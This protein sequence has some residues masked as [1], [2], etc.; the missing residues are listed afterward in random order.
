MPEANSLTAGT[1][2]RFAT[3]WPVVYADSC[4]ALSRWF[5]ETI[6]REVEI[7]THS[8]AVKNLGLPNITAVEGAWPEARYR[9]FQQS[10]APSTQAVFEAVKAVPRLSTRSYPL[11][12]FTAH[13]HRLIYLGGMLS[14]RDMEEP[15]LHL[16]VFDNRG[17]QGERLGPDW[18]SL[19]STNSNFHVVDIRDVA[20]HDTPLFVPPLVTRLR[21]G[22]LESA[23]YYTALRLWRSLP[24]RLGRGVALIMG[25]N[26]LQREA[27]ASLALK[28]F[29]L[30]IV[31]MP[32]S[33]GIDAP[34]E[35]DTAAT[36][37]GSG[38]LSAQTA[39]WSSVRIGRQLDGL[40]QRQATAMLARHRSMTDAC[41]R[42]L[43][44]HAT[45]G[46]T[47]LLVDSAATIAR[48]PL[49]EAARRLHIPVVSCQH[50]VT[51]EIR[52]T[53][54]EVAVSYENGASDFLF[55]YNAAAA[56]VSA[57]SIYARGQSIATGAPRIFRR[58]EA[59]RK[60]DFPFMYISTTLL[61]S[62][63]NAF[64][65]WRTDI[66][67]AGREAAFIDGVLAKL[68]GR[69]LYKPYPAIRYADANPVV[70]HARTVANLSIVDRAIDLRYM[71]GNARVM[72]TMRATSTLGWCLA[73]KR[74][75]V[76]IDLPGDNPLS[77][78]AKDA[79]KPS[80]FLFDA[81]EPDWMES[82]VCLLSQ[83]LNL[84]EDEW[85]RRKS[86]RAKALEALV[87]GPQQSAGKLAAREILASLRQPKLSLE[88]PS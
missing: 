4:E 13:F 32:E 84:L 49:A 75:V 78:D 2:A 87:F 86:S 77:K 56:R 44:P 31:G 15:R 74:P 8:P 21:F 70:A 55:T 20:L 25:D 61:R 24:A 81:G 45:K 79:L 82:I 73:S 11:A 16:R 50:G 67:R 10:I 60:P 18:S 7:R 22:G 39:R 23:T 29:A 40:Y 26:E 36:S 83:D 12:L 27:A 51:R 63:F 9:A 5:G 68:P 85:A 72:L 1:A 71:A 30:Q 35:D 28:G 17:A 38:V 54:D 59:S 34:D 19:L 33:A 66:E 43:T 14:D 52:D 3:D 47:V 53:D 64:V 48:L 58:V 6:P 57:K 62:S 76:F 46:R 69:V 37:I 80:L 41:H 65:G 88:Q 42:T